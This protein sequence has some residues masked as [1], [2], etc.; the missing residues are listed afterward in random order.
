MKLPSY[1]IWLPWR[2]RGPRIHISVFV[3]FTD[4]TIT[5]T[6]RKPGPFRGLLRLDMAAAGN[7]AASLQ[8][9]TANTQSFRDIAQRILG[10]GSYSNAHINDEQ[11]T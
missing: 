1:Q 6:F 9:Q 5:V 2:S 3:V 11:A 4:D 10:R 8:V 7:I